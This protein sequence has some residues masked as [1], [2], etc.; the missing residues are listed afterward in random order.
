MS[1]HFELPGILLTSATETVK[2]PSWLK[3]VP[4]ESRPASELRFLARLPAMTIVQAED[5]ATVLSRRPWLTA[6]ADLH[7]HE[8]TARIVFAFR[9]ASHQSL[10]VRMRQYEKLLSFFVRASSIELAP[11]P[12]DARPA[13][14]EAIAKYLVE[15]K[16]ARP[17]PAPAPS[18]T[19]PLAGVRRVLDATAALRSESGRLD[20]RRV[21]GAFGLSVAELAGLLGKSRQAVSK[22]PDS[23][24]LQ[25]R[26][27]P[28]ERIARLRAVLSQADFRSWLNL[29]NDQLEGQAP[30]GI[31][32]A[33]RPEVVAN[34]AEDLLT[35]APA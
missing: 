26:L 8:S 22:T 35:G 29:A 3:D 4:H 28:F 15:M 34:L 14:E 31:V 25:P 16:A 24:S 9:K 32:R 1:S 21:A 27:R 13:F 30:L 18:P 33:G 12:A 19:D 23:D 6:L 10:S 7:A 5:A 2:V 17:A 11:G 20:A